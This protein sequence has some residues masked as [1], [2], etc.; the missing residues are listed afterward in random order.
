MSNANLQRISALEDPVKASE[1]A[2]KLLAE[3]S[4]PQKAKK[5][6]PPPPPQSDTV[7]EL[8]GGLLHPTEGLIR[9]V[10]VR[11]LT[12][13]DE[14]KLSRP[15][16][17]KNMHTYI[18]AILECGVVRIGS[19]EPDHTLLE[20]L[21]LGDREFLVLAIRRATYGDELDLEIVCPRCDARQNIVYDLGKEVPI[22]KLEDPM[23]LVYEI[24]L[25]KGG[26]AEVVLP[27]GSAQGA[28]FGSSEQKRSAGELNSILLSRCVQS[29][30][31]EPAVGLASVQ[32]LGI[33]DRRTI[34]KFL[35]EI[36]PGPQFEDVTYVCAS[37]AHE[38]PMVVNVYEL[39]RG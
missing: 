26:V 30:D 12:G 9:R 39:F 2:T 24:P 7:V 37:C 22:R 3:V 15:S 13:A 14:E 20:S 23:K 36:Q 19:L 34:L 6:P 18:S 5:E 8:P 17:T 11:E 29:I 33:R 1:I 38:M 28:L 10:E 32:R 25:W 4:N 31:G 35:D 21:L 16:S 27:T